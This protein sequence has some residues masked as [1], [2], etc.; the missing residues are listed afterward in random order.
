MPRARNAVTTA[1][2]RSQVLTI[3]AVARLPRPT[4]VAAVPPRFAHALAQGH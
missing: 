1:F 2:K 3:T 4:A